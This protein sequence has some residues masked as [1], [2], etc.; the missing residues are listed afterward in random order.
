MEH[1][2]SEASYSHIDWDYC[3]SAISESERGFSYWGSCYSPISPQYV[4]QFLGPGSLSVVQPGF[5][6][7]K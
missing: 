5:D 7:L 2:S 3:L 4:G 1:L 6:D